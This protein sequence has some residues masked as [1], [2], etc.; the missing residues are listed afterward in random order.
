[1]N[2]TVRATGSNE[3]ELLAA[4]EDVVNAIRVSK[5]HNGTV[6]HAVGNIG[7]YAHYS[8]TNVEARQHHGAEASGRTATQMADSYVPQGSRLSPAPFPSLK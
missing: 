6:Q 4:L 7:Y 8:F 2:L 3:D 5:A 1:M